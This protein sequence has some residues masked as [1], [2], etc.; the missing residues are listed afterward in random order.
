MEFTPFTTDRLLIRPYTMAD[1]P[2]AF[3]IFSDPVVMAQCEPP[4]TLHKTEDMLACFIKQNIAFAVVKRDEQRV[5]GHLLFKQL[6]REEQGIFEMGWI[7]N[8]SYWRSGFAFEAACAIIRYG[9][10]TLNL[11]KICAETIDPHKSVPMMKKLGM[12]QE[13]H[14]RQHTRGPGGNWAD[15]YWYA[16]LR[17]EENA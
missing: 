2:D 11:H 1:V 10:D 13:G 3:Q 6:P 14:F 17:G 7:F 8:Q 9:F 4:Y 15:V 5:I 12:R 16:I